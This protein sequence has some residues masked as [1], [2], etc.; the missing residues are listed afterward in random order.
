MKVL[1]TGASGFVGQAILCR[2]FTDKKYG[3]K[4]AY[5]SMPGGEI[6]WAVCQ[7]PE[8]GSLGSLGSWGEALAGSDLVIHA[9]AKVHVM[10]DKALDPLAEY[11][12]V[13]VEGTLSLATQAANLGVKR[14][15]FISSIKVNGETTNPGQPFTADDTPAPLDPY[16]IS[17]LEAEERLMAL[18]KSTGMQVVIIR[19]VLVYGK[20][21]KG[22][23]A[24]LTRMVAK[25][26]PLPFGA[27]HNKRSLVALDNL[28]DL[29]V[30]CMDHP[31]AANRVFLAADG[32]SLSTSDLLRR[33]AAAMGKPSRLLP[34][35]A[36][37][38]QLGAAILGKKSM[39]Q[40]LLGSLEVDIAKSRE[41]LGWV[42]PVPVDEGLRRCFE[43]DRDD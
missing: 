36:G 2:L 42:P 40:R 26:L 22:N 6:P 13:N 25:G 14:F 29:I 23:F 20:R 33:V 15:I 19:P 27:I 32:E 5:R 1:V 31:S 38:L 43:I 35:P 7:A 11:R 21:V 17:K 10:S 41:V 8:L 4:G 16:G 18:S 3:V 37:L 24:S 30:T 9:A 39:A 28:V 12:E 34:V